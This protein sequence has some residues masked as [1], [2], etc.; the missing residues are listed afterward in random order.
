MKIFPETKGR[1][2]KVAGEPTSTG[3]VEPDAGG[4]DAGTSGAD[5]GNGSESL[6]SDERLSKVIDLLFGSQLAQQRAEMQRLEHEAAERVRVLR[7][8]LNQ[9]AQSLERLIDDKANAAMQREEAAYRRRRAAEEQ[10][11]TK[12]RDLEEAVARATERLN[13]RTSETEATLRELVRSQYESLSESLETSHTDTLR[14]LN[15]GLNELANSK[16]DRKAL[17]ALLAP[18]VLQLDPQEAPDEDLET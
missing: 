13:G 18:V 14:R 4:A 7:E 12:I 15:Q 9:Q 2:G 11:E 10:L 6:S 16:V 1:R 5:G 8:E 3:I 17:A